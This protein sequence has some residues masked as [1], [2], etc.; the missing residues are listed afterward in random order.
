MCV[1]RDEES[2]RFKTEWIDLCK[3]AGEGYR[4]FRSLEDLSTHTL[5]GKEYP[6]EW[7]AEV[8]DWSA[9]P[10]GFFT[11]TGVDLGIGEKKGSDL[12]VF[13]TVLVWPDGTRQVLEIEAGRYPGPVIV[14][15]ILKKQDAFRSRVI[16]ESVAAQRY[17]VQFANQASGVGRIP[18]VP[19]ATTA[20]NKWNPQFGVESLGVELSNGAWLIPCSVDTGLGQPEIEAWISEMLNYQP[21]QHTGDRLMAS[22][23]VREHVRRVLA[24]G[25]QK[26]GNGS[27]SVRVIGGKRPKTTP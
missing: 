7:V 19:F 5:D 10:E 21:D 12:T 23:F 25:G 1:P 3:Q 11:V 18:V 4:M 17:I 16:V 14:Q 8:D 26:K 9:W 13:F 20:K 15:K 22:W 6:L 2:S 24:R 27:V